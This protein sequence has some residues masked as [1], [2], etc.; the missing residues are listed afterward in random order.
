MSGASSSQLA[1]LSPFCF[2]QFFGDLIKAKNKQKLSSQRSVRRSTDK[3]PIG[4]GVGVEF[5][6]MD[7][8]SAERNSKRIEKFFSGEF[9][10]CSALLLPLPLLLPAAAA[11]AAVAGAG[12]A[13]LPWRDRR[14]F[15]R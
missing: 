14:V 2:K 7:E 8:D 12:A 5:A 11:S 1:S 10:F 3:T 13:C 15:Y 9:C 4:V 6:K